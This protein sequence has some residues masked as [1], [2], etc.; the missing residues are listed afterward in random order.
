MN[1]VKGWNNQMISWR[2]TKI[3]EKE[4]NIDD[5]KRHDV[6]TIEKPFRTK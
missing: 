2:G 1:F 5:G 6:I 3:K 4:H